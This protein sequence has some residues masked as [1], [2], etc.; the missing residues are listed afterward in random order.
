MTGRGRIG[1]RTV[2]GVPVVQVSGD[3]DIG[4][5]GALEAALQEA[6][7]ADVGF[8]VVSLE[9]TQYMDSRTIHVFGQFIGRIA[10]NRQELVF[11]VPPSCR[12]RVLL[13][14]TGLLSIME[15]EADLATALKRRRP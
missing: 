11:V 13:E 6:V 7:Q 3:V 4:N 14:F 1:V 15:V 8:M 9:K 2:A 5:V 12:A 10:T